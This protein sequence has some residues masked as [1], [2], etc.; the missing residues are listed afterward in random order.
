MLHSNTR[1]ICP[2]KID[3]KETMMFKMLS[4]VDSMIQRFQWV[5]F[6]EYRNSLYIA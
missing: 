6:Q 5:N 2:Q 1:N 4:H 3:I